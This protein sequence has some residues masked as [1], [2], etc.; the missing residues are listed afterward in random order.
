[1]VQDLERRP[2]P[3]THWQQLWD[4]YFCHCKQFEGITEVWKSLHRWYIQTLSKTIYPIRNCTYWVFTLVMC[5]MTG[6]TVVQY[7]Q[8]IQHLKQ[9]VRHVSGHRWRPD[10]TICDFEQGLKLAIETELPNT[11][12]KIQE[13][14]LARQYRQG[15]RLRKTLRKIMTIYTFQW[16]WYAKGQPLDNR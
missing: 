6:K 7:W 5:L 3:V 11:M 9:R 10:I 16:A 8:V 1:M 2:F 14:G 4:S 12:I 13:L 15:R